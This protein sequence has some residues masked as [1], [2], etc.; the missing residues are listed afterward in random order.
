MKNKTKAYITGISVLFSAIMA[1]NVYA[2]D[3]PL[4]QVSEGIYYHQGAQEDADQHN[5]GEIANT[6]FI[7]GDKCIAVVDSGGSYLEGKALLAAIREKSDLPICYV[8]NTHAHPDHFLGNAAFKDTG[9]TFIGNAKMPA[10]IEARKS[11]YETRF[12]EIL[13]KY[14][15]G[16]EFIEPTLLVS[17]DKPITIDLGNRELVLNSYPTSHTD[18][19]LT[20]LDKK[21]K[22]LWAGDLLFV[23][24][25][26]A[27]DGSINGWLATIKKLEAMKLNAVIPGHGPA[28]YKD[29]HQ[30]FDA[31]EHYFLTI[32]EQIRAIIN[33][34]GTIT[35]ATGSVGLSEKGKWLLF[36]DYNKRNVTAAFTELEWE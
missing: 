10:A 13:G 20:V 2:D 17:V 31:E 26:P 8:I 5:K 3:Y 27:L 14:F 35:E 1:L 6:G 9:A 33:D 18:N 29:W 4:K 36:D 22:T 32:R 16:T 15:K 12:Q 7:M 19:D 24:R 11:F 25:I 30:A 28:Q 23:K 21:T 34:M